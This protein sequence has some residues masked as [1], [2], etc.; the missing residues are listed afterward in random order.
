MTTPV[1]QKIRDKKRTPGQIADMMKSGEWMTNGTVGGDP[2]ACMEALAN[3]LGD[4]PSNLRDMEI[5]NYGKFYPQL[6]FQEVDP[7][8]KYHCF[9]DYFFFPWNRKARD[10]H[11]VTSWAQWGWTI[12]SWWH[13]YRFADGDPKKRGIDWF[14]NAAT[15]VDHNGFFNWSYGTNN[16]NIFRESAKRLVVE[17]REDYPWAEGGR[18]NTIHIDDVDYWVEVDCEKYAWPQIDE[19]A[20]VP[21]QQEKQIAEHILTIMDDRDVLQLGIGSLPSAC[22]AAMAN[23]GLKDL[24]IH[25][26][27]LN[28]GLIKLIESGQVT[29]RY[30]TLDRGKSVWTFA[31]PVD[32]KWY[33]DTIDRNQHL[34]VYDADYTNNLN[35]ITR[36]DN[37]I[38][39]NNCIAIDLLGQQSAGFYKKRPISSTGGYFQFMCFCSQSRGGRGVACMTSRNKEGRSRIVPFLPEGSSVDLPA[40]FAHYVCTEYGIVNL[41][42]LNG[43]ERTS[44]LIS[45]A[46]PDDRE[47]LEREA[48]AHGLLAPHF[49]VS[50]KPE[51]GGARR[52]PSYKDK[53]NYKVPANSAVWGYDWDP[54]QSGK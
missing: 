14:L 49:P 35:V 46:H 37:M 24:G 52:Y 51:E 10:D 33:Y 48:H 54:I 2:T 3:R 38:A 22:V 15:P 53:R 25:T 17:V 7:F 19:K 8:Q 26:E 9:H 41:R 16:C 30:K 4:G 39:I 27:M 29:N 45:I 18:F 5:W 40:Q 32:T 28:Y 31:F 44:A 43:Y 20:M 21:T 47:W 1:Q 11:G 13:H 36:I 34:A 23:A 6:R 42:G 50:M 12:G